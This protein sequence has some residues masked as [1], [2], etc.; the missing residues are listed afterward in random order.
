MPGIENIGYICPQGNPKGHGKTNWVL[1]SGWSPKTFG[2]HEAAVKFAA[3]NNI[4]IRSR[5]PAEVQAKADAMLKQERDQKVR[6]AAIRDAA[7]VP[8]WVVLWP[9]DSASSTW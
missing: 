6:D 1:F 8:E 7:E 4:Q 3:K 5:V 2:S 9:G